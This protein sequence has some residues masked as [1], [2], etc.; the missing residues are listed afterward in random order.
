MGRSDLFLHLIFFWL[1]AN[2]AVIAYLTLIYF[3]IGLSE[4]FN[5]GGAA[6]IHASRGEGRARIL[7]INDLSSPQS[8][9]GF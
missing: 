8:G 3:A 5:K 7:M 6:E 9:R 4:K 1:V 2:T